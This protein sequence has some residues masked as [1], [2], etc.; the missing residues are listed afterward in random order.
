MIL[1]LIPAVLICLLRLS[2]QWTSLRIPEPIS[3]PIF[4]LLLYVA[5]SF[6][7]VWVLYL[8]FNQLENQW[9]TTSPSCWFSDLLSPGRQSCRGQS[10]DFSDHVVLFYAQIL[11]PVL[12][13]TAHSLSRPLLR[14]VFG[15]YLCYLEVVVAIE[16]YKT[17]AYFHTPGEVAVGFLVSCLVAVPLAVAQCSTSPIRFA[18]RWFNL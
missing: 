8:F 9:I 4:R 5:L 2:G 7:R 17:T 6:F 3:V 13:E 1:P 10:F 11:P 12:V 18:G 16:T 15:T 14:W